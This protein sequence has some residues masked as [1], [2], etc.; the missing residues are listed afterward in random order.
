[1]LV[2]NVIDETCKRENTLL[3]VILMLGTVW[4]SVRIFEFNSSPFLSSSLREFVSD[5][6]LP[7]SVIIFSFIGSYLFKEVEGGSNSTHH[8]LVN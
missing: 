5:Y 2:E 8:H 4:L 6:A 3:F 7:L 1:M